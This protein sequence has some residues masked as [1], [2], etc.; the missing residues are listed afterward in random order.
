MCLFVCVPWFLI[1]VSHVLKKFRINQLLIKEKNMLSQLLDWP[2]HSFFFCFFY[3]INWGI[4]LSYLSKTSQIHSHTNF[5]PV[6]IFTPC[7]HFGYLKIFKMEDIMDFCLRKYKF[8]HFD[9]L[10]LSFCWL[11]GLWLHKYTFKFSLHNFKFY[12]TI[13]SFISTFKYNFFLLFFLNF[14]FI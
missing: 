7:K 4:D 3:C 5:L 9:L 6:A 12:N 2:L 13:T 14:Y 1:N 10:F 11:M 8:T